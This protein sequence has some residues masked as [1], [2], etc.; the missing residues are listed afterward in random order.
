MRHSPLL[1]VSLLAGCPDRTIAEVNPDQRSVETKLVPAI[2]NRDVDILFVIDNSGSMAEEQASLRANFAKF[3]DVLATIEGGI[4]NVHIGVTTSNLGQSASDGVGAAGFGTQCAGKGDDGALRGGAQINGRFIVDEEGSV[5]TRKRNYSGTLAD[6]FASI[7]DVGTGGC[8]IEQH[9]AAAQRALVNPVNAGFLR[10]SAKLAVIFIA[11]EDDC[12]LSHKSLFEGTLDGSVVN[13]RCTQESIECEGGG[14]DLSIP[15]LRTGCSPRV[16]SPYLNDVDMYADYLRSLKPNPDIDVLVAGIVGDPE[17]FEIVTD[18]KQRP[19]L[20][21]SCT[22]GGQFAYPAVRTAELLSQFPQSARATICDG[23]LSRALVEIAVELKR[24]LVPACLE[25]IPADVDPAPGLQAECAVSDYR[26]RG[27]GSREELG[28]VPACGKG[29]IPCWRLELDEKNC[30]NEPT[31]L[32]LVVDRGGEIPSS[33]VFV[34][35]SC[36]TT[37]DTGPVQ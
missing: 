1:L 17:P 21:A 20:G 18:D 26:I 9:M 8:G 10:P 16:G 23:D 19:V 14:L 5:G 28:V 36:V 35:A 32:K 22:Y 31:K 3:M 6:A 24:S 25:A 27:D 12:S 29:D 37:D 13:F 7:A 33:D 15:G 4:P 11:D 34:Q 2:P 30:G